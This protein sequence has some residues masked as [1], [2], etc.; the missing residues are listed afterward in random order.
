[1]N[2]IRCIDELVPTVLNVFNRTSTIELSEVSFYKNVA[3]DFIPDH[4]ISDKRTGKIF[5]DCV[6]PTRPVR[7]SKNAFDSTRQHTTYAELNNCLLQD[8]D[9]SFIDG[10]TQMSYL[11]ITNFYEM[12][13]SFSTFPTN[14]QFIS[15]LKLIQCSG[16]DTL[17]NPSSPIVGA[18][19]LARLDITQSFDMNDDV[20]NMVMEWTAASFNSTLKS[21]YIYSNNLTRIPPQIELFGAMD[22]LDISNNLFALIPA[23]SLKFKSNVLSLIDISNCGV[24]DIE[25]SA[26]VGN[27]NIQ[28]N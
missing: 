13:K 9:F 2:Y 19:R 14:L 5:F 23:G 12:G 6:Y 16:W 24:R 25:S 3:D 4:L 20:M 8:S 15:N 1:M 7:V 10:F 17:V 27:N 26:F 28:I 11:S 18:T 22:V 21:L